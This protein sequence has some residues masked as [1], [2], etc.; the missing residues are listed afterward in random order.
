MVFDYG[1]TLVLYC[2]VYQ[3]KP[4][5][6]YSD[7]NYHLEKIG[8]FFARDFS[9]SLNTSYTQ[10]KINS[11]I[12]LPRNVVSSHPLKR[13][14][15]ISVSILNQVEPSNASEI[16]KY[17]VSSTD[18]KYIYKYHPQWADHPG[19]ENGTANKTRDNVSSEIRKRYL[20]NRA[21]VVSSVESDRLVLM[22]Y[23]QYNM[24]V[25]TVGYV[26]LVQNESFVNITNLISKPDMRAFTA[27]QYSFIENGQVINSPFVFDA[28]GKFFDG[29]SFSDNFTTT[30][31][32]P[33]DVLLNALSGLPDE[34]IQYVPE[35]YVFRDEGG[36]YI[37]MSITATNERADY[38]DTGMKHDYTRSLRIKPVVNAKF[39][40]LINSDL[41]TIWIQP[42]SDASD[43]IR[44]G[45]VG[46]IADRAD[47]R[48][49]TLKTF[50]KLSEADR[51]S[52]D[53][54]TEL[55]TVLIGYN[56]LFNKN[57]FSKEK[58]K[59]GKFLE[60]EPDRFYFSSN[61]EYEAAKIQY[62]ERK[63]AF[64]DKIKELD[65]KEKLYLAELK[66]RL[67]YPLSRQKVKE[68]LWEA[69]NGTDD[70]SDMVLDS[71]ITI[72]KWRSNYLDGL[73]YNVLNAMQVQYKSAQI[74]VS[75]SDFYGVKPLEQISSWYTY[76][77]FW[78][79]PSGTDLNGETFKIIRTTFTPT[80]ISYI[81]TGA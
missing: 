29:T 28:T 39:T 35:A 25:V 62:E 75:S 59:L 79:S 50:D 34:Y 4:S 20:Y 13:G 52:F 51:H 12:S 23:I 16:K 60:K 15:I 63:K 21:F 40:P 33:Y 43:Y 48:K 18:S 49:K 7:E 30:N 56:D 61:E 76:D 14:D 10:D 46:V 1:N 78:S 36:P 6:F 11:T 22:D 72:P 38:I 71:G 67:G 9:I 32:K 66:K 19:T 27:K 3:G 2:E 41:S 55:K 80:Q 47:K 58:E 81:M 54:I 31:V 45:I 65:D 57:Y 68:L 37:F 64:D 73:K 42:S 44:A 5:L 70:T 53:T 17:I 69:I 74:E 8:S 24:S 77:L 26:G